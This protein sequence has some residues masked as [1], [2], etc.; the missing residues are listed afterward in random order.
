MRLRL[1]KLR[2]RRRFRKSQQQVEDFSL[3]AEKQIE[4]HFFKR[5]ERLTSVKRFVAGWLTLV[6]LLIAGL[7]VQNI[8]LSGYFQTLKPVPGGIY[9]EGLHG[10]F[11]TAN[12]LYAT[13]NVDTVVARLVFAGLFTYDDKNNLVGDLAQSYTVEE[14]GATYTVKL[15]SNLKWQDGTPLT[16][17]DVQFTY[18]TIQNPDARSPLQ[19]SWQGIEVTAPD[20]QTVIFKLADPLASFP[21]NMTNGIVPKHLLKDVPVADLRTIDFNTIN[22]IGAGPFAWQTIQVTGDDPTNAEEQ[23]DLVPFTDYHGGKPKLQRFVVHAY[24]DLDKMTKDF[25]NKKLNGATDLEK[26]LPEL[27]N[28]AGVEIHNYILSASTMVFFKTTA[29]ILSDVK[30]RQALVSA[31]DVPNIA[32]KLGYPTRLVR[33]PLLKGQLAYNNKY[34][35][36]AFDL[37]AAQTLLASD[38]WVKGEDGILRKGEQRLSFNLAVADTPEYRAVT[39]ALQKQ[40]KKLGAEVQ[41]R[42]LNSADFQNTLSGHTYDAILHG[43][44]IGVDPDVFVYWD[45][46]QADVRAANRLNLSEYKNSTADAALE[47]GRTRTLPALRVIKYEPFLRVWQTDAPALGLYQ[48][49]MLYMTNG[50]VAGLDEHVINASTD[51]FNNVQNWQIRQAKVTN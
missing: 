20:D 5:F 14:K 49:R 24:A 9:A 18:Q 35:Q 31:S 13:N 16:S 28:K 3:H 23:I 7:V 8:L 44:S 47:A 46:S 25:K 29:G 17:A 37:V 2:F 43:I 48:P 34:Q 12:P 51:R 41:L 11:S 33:E 45:S 40:W 4:R 22:P 30:V 36:A 15:K 19:S 42:Y 21:Y 38:G 26:A 39:L 10:T 50:S 32:S 27:Q 1:I 6:V